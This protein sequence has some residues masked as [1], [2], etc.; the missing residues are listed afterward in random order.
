MPNR[1][2]TGA[3]RIKQNHLAVHRWA[4][5]VCLAPLKRWRLVSEWTPKGRRPLYLTDLFWRWLSHESLTRL[6][7]LSATSWHFNLS[8][9]HI[10]TIQKEQNSNNLNSWHVKQLIMLIEYCSLHIVIWPCTVCPNDEP[11][12]WILSQSPVEGGQ[13]SHR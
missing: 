4:M 12:L 6:P 11:G 7:S 3:N 13:L 1:E 2:D 8:S 9:K 5:N 10:K